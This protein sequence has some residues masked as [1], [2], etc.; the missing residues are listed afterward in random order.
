MFKIICEKCNSDLVVDRRS[1]IDKYLEDMRYIVNDDGDILESTLQH[2]LMYRC[3]K[4][5]V[6]KE[7][8]YEEWELLCRKDIAREAMEIK[9]YEM[10]KE[11]NPQSINQ[12]NGVSHCGQCS[13][14]G[15]DGYCLNDIIKQCTIRK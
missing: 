14:Y 7:L 4:C 9:K 15:D 10:F 1:T 6:I 2:Y 5:K 12:D 3:A 13:G 11:M 8:T